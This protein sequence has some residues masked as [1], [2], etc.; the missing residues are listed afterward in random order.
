MNIDNIT[1]RVSATWAN[2]ESSEERSTKQLH[3]FPQIVKN[4][5]SSPGI[6]ID[7]LQV[8]HK[9]K[10]N[11]NDRQLSSKHQ[12]ISTHAL[13]TQP[14]NRWIPN[15]ATGRQ[16]Q[17]ES[18]KARD[19]DNDTYKVKKRVSKN[20]TNLGKGLIGVLERFCFGLLDLY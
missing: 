5:T 8:H 4:L 15:H 12:C 16:K 10:G 17:K 13:S 20:V 6:Q 1:A 18:E 11:K 9:L 2:Y 14:V 7:A 3:D 19:Q